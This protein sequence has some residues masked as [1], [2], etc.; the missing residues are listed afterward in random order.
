MT[1]K[2]TWTL[3]SQDYSTY[4][5]YLPQTSLLTFGLYCSMT[6]SYKVVKNR[7][8]TEQSHIEL[9]NLTIKSILYTCTI[10]TYTR[11]PTFGPFHYMKW[12]L[13]KYKVAKNL[14]CT[15]WPQTELEHLAVKST[16]YTGIH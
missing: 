6:S 8:C 14:N 1:P 12:Q 13:S 16:L 2:W 3:N 4:T 9:E 11:G 15:K 5:K 10:N 7:N